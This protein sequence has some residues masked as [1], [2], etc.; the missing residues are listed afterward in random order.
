LRGAAVTDVARVGTS[1]EA[2]G[3]WKVGAIIVT[4]SLTIRQAQPP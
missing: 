1:T 2:F 3:S 4:L